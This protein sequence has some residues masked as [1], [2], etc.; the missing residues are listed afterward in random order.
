MMLIH[1]V[2][3]NSYQ[4]QPVQL[5]KGNSMQKIS[6]DIRQE[7]ETLV[8]SSFYD[9]NRL[10][11]I[12]HEEMYA[13][14]ELNADELKQ[15]IDELMQQHEQAKST[16]THTTDN[17]K[18]TDSFSELNQMG[19]IALENAGH[20]QSDGYDDVLRI[21]Q[22]SADPSKY[23]GYCY[24][25]SQDMNRGILGNGIFLSFGSIDAQKEETVGVEVG[26]KIV[27]VLQKH[28][29]QTQWDGT[30]NQRIQIVNF[31]WQRR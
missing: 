10:F 30:F 20:T 2:Y 18:L 3:A 28:G 13:P 19:I 4:H 5:M 24:Y 16:W 7:I 1:P 15:V 14:N 11:T 25:H 8:N 9:K 17:D 26:Q 12:F 22:R 29:L 6:S 27:E 23:L 31:T 21:V